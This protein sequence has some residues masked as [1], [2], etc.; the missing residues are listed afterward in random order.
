VRFTLRAATAELAGKLV[1]A[2]TKLIRIT[3][4]FEPWTLVDARGRCVDVET[5]ER[6]QHRK[7]KGPSSRLNSEAL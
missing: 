4:Q 6:R 5:S 3:R 1:A 7:Q 2:A